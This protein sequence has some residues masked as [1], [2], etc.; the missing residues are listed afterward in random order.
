VIPGWLE[1]V[2]RVFILDVWFVQ[3]WTLRRKIV[4]TLC[5]LLLFVVAVFLFISFSGQGQA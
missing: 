5:L 4:W 2:F 3:E 1:S